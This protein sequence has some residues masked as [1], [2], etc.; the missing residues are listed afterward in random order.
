MAFVCRFQA[1]TAS[2]AAMLLRNTMQ[3]QLLLSINAANT[4]T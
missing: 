4:I 3:T 2:I 1:A